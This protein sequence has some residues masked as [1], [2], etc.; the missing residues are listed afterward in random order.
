MQKKLFYKIISFCTVIVL[1]LP[2]SLKFLH[3]LE[4]H[5]HKICTSKNIPHFHEQELDCSFYHV[6]LTTNA[7]F[8]SNKITLY[9][10]IFY[11]QNPILKN[12]NKIGNITYQKSSR[13]P[14]VFIV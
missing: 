2:M 7:L 10:S 5:E 1:L 4:N 11:L 3:S 12:S 8:V 13:A 6:Q 9:K 14:P